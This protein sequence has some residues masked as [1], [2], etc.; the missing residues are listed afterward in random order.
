MNESL[1][2]LYSCGLKVILDDFISSI[3]PDQ[4]VMYNEEDLHYIHKLV[5][6]RKPFTTLEFGV[7]FSSITIA[8]AIMMNKQ[9][10]DSL[11]T[12]PALRNSALFRHYVVDSSENWLQNTKSKF[13]AELLQFINFNFSDVY[14]EK[15]GDFQLCSL[16]RNIPDV[17]P[18]FIYLDGPDPKDVLGEINGLSFQNRERTVM[19]AD[20]LLM[21]STFLPGTF[22]LVDGR[23]NNV[24]FLRNN[25]KRNYLFNWDKTGDR[26]TFEL[27]EERLGQ[28][29]ILGSDFY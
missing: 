15:L 23:T 6:Q 14:I 17:V 16:Y 13:P 20:L 8:H 5:R 22:I 9:E 26:S 21:E 24:R 29:N 28:Y 18:E 2:Y 27:D 4:K 11:K 7:G 12:K 10:F 1:R 3:D 19:S 25:F